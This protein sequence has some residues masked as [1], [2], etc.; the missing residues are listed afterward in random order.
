MTKLR[1]S[2]EDSHPNTEGHKYISEVLY[3][4]YKKISS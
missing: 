4:E 3:D 1:V 2:D